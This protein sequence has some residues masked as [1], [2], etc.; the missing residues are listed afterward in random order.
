MNETDLLRLLD[1]LSDITGFL[2][3]LG[4][5]ILGLIVL[6]FINIYIAVVRPSKD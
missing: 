5:M 4:N 2:N 1:I 6:S 3:Y